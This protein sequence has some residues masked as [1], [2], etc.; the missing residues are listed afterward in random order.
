[1]KKKYAVGWIV[2]FLIIMIVPTATYP[3]VKKYIDTSNNEKRD[4]KEKPELTADTYEEFPK[5]FE[6]YY[7]DNLPYRSQWVTLNS[8]IDYFL[9]HQSSSDSVVV[10]KDG[11]LFYR[12]INDGNSIEQSMGYILLSDEQLR[13]IAENLSTTKK[14]LESQGIEFVVF[15]LPNKSAI[16]PEKLPDYYKRM[17]EKTMTDQLIEYLG[18]HTD[19]QIIYPKEEILEVK[20]KNP[21]IVLYKKL[22]THWNRVG[23]YVGAKYFV[24]QF[25]KKLPDIEQIYFIQ[26]SVSG[27]DLADMLNLSIKDGDLSYEMDYSQINDRETE[28]EKDDYY[29]E[30]IYHTKDAEG[31]NLVVRRDSF[32]DSMMPVIATQFQ[33]SY[34]LHEATFENQKIFDYDADLFVLEMVERHIVTGSG[35]KVSFISS[36]IHEKKDGT[37]ILSISP[38]IE[39]NNVPYVSV[40]VINSYDDVTHIQSL[41]KFDHSIELDVPADEEGQVR[42]QI[43]SDETGKDLIEESMIEY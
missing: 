27:G 33:N 11:W 7:N 34:F 14:V 21:D 42:V 40:D 39:G 19:I 10:G 26:K 24:E 29:G 13:T 6:E 16:Y 17:S 3:F 43:F 23:G 38:A 8:S 35:F 18:K 25:G 36:V 12:D 2:M 41:S 20:E 22:D 28:C 4:M 30:Y 37:K 32:S 31:K 5:Q 15:I 9:F 1:M